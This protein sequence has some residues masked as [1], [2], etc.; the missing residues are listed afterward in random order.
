MVVICLC[1]AL[2]GNVYSDVACFLVHKCVAELCS[3]SFEIWGQSLRSF[4][5][6]RWERKEG[7]QLTE[8][9][10][11]LLVPSVEASQS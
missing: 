3:E 6:L 9:V 5:A 1:A 7:R 2:F 8:T 11:P 10:R 4:A